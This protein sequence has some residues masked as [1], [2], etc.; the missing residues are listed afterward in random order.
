MKGSEASLCEE[1]LRE[2]ELFN[3]QKR[4]LVWD[5]VSAYQCL[6]GGC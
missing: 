4:G 2:L 1:K 6:K 5:L 3:L